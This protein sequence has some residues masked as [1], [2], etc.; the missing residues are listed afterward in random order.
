MQ[1]NQDLNE[2]NNFTLLMPKLTSYRDIQNY[3]A[4]PNTCTRRPVQVLS[5]LRH[6]VEISCVCNV[7]FSVEETNSP[8][9]LHPKRFFQGMRPRLY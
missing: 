2:Y 5:V 7:N 8:S 4:T 3:N 1:E 6:T 9:S